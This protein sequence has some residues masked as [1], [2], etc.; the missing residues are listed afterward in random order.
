MSGC[1]QVMCTVCRTYLCWLCGARLSSTNPYQHYKEKGPCANR[2][3]GAPAHAAPLPSSSTVRLQGELGS[4][5]A[6]HMPLLLAGFFLSQ[7]S[8][9]T[10]CCERA[11]AVRR[12]VPVVA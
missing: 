10:L 7:H 6:A 4:F 2:I 9:C 5:A 1:N 11:S 3:Y 8:V 12:P